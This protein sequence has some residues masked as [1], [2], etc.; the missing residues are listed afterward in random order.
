MAYTEPEFRS[1]PMGLLT[2]LLC[3]S[4]AA[5]GGGEPTDSPAA[6]GANPPAAA[7][8]PSPAPSPAPA[9]PP[10]PSAL[11]PGHQA[12]DL[13]GSDWLEVT[14]DWSTAH[15]ARPAGV[16][17]GYDWRERGAAHA[18][19][20]VPA[21]F[22][23]FTGWAQAFWADGAPVGGQRLELRRM[24][25]LLC[26]N[27]A[28][29]RQWQR[30][31]QGDIEG[32]SFKADFAEDQN[33]PAEI[34]PVE[35]GQVRVGFAGGRAFHWWPRQGRV[36]LGSPE[37]CGM[38]VLFQARAVA[39]DGRELP[40]GTASALLVGAGADYWLDTRVPWDH[41]RTNASVGVGPLRLARP[42]WRWFG[43]S[44]ADT[45][46]LAQLQREGYVDRSSP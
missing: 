36:G 9:A 13:P 35:P 25:T 7:A 4:L 14:R 27:T 45:A 6:G 16:P 40:E 28:G 11:P 44:T 23:A 1:L 34:T 17:A 26:R 43:I 33:V 37:L 18:G 2:S 20:R 15:E 32:A 5:C 46:S 29:V 8:P 12:L 3:L 31:Q 10:R 41:F 24:Q 22:A 38:L 30:V 39:A 21:G 42:H 19:N